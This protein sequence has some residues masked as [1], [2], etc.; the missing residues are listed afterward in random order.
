MS[1]FNYPRLC[2]GGSRS[3][4]FT[5]VAHRSDFLCYWRSQLPLYWWFSDPHQK[6]M[7]FPEAR[8][9]VYLYGQ[10]RGCSKI[11]GEAP[12]DGLWPTP[13]FATI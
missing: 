1:T 2:R 3:L 7:F 6:L 9:R 8:V 10:T 4:T 12:L 13:H 11:P 5:G